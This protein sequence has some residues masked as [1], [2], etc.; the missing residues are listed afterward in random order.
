M[1]FKKILSLIFI[2]VISLTLIGCNGGNSGDDSRDRA[3]LSS[4]VRV[5]SVTRDYEYYLKA[6]RTN[7][8]YDDWS[9]FVTVYYKYKGRDGSYSEYS[10]SVDIPKG[11]KSS[12]VRLFLTTVNASD[13]RISEVKVSRGI[14]IS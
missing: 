8:D 9:L 7:S 12:E 1:K 5:T 2:F 11:Q 4:S 3:D 14:T 6:T 13:F 10:K